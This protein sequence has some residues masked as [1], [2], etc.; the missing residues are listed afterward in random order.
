MIKDAED[1]GLI[2]PGKVGNR[3][4]VYIYSS[5]YE[6]SVWWLLFPYNPIRFGCRHT[7]LKYRLLGF[8]NENFFGC[9]HG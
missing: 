6:C 9:G 3:T 1:K 2:T 5:I 4:L 7:M 8:L